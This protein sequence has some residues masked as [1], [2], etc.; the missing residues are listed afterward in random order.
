MRDEPERGGGEWWDLLVNDHQHEEP[1]ETEHSRDGRVPRGS[2]PIFGRTAGEPAVSEA[3]E[4]R[5]RDRAALWSQAHWIE[6]GASDA[7]DRSLEEASPHRKASGAA[8][9]FCAALH[10]RRRGAAGRDRYGAR[11]FVRAGDPPYSASRVHR[12]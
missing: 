3:K 2:L 5:T 8:A 7:A 12:L 4:E 11:E 9:P 6:P 1:G 10:G